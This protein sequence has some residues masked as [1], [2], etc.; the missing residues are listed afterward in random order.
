MIKKSSFSRLMAVSMS[1]C[2]QFWGSRAICMACNTVYMFELY[3]LKL[4]VFA[5]YDCFHELLPI[6]FGFRVIC[7]ARNTLYMFEIYDQKL[8]VFSFYGRSH[9][10]LPTISGF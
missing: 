4:V 5:F 6:V 3:D 7:M 10:L 2:P 8:F 1:Y 9:A